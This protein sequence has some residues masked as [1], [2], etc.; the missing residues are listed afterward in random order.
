MLKSHTR[1]QIS[2]VA[3][4]QDREGSEMIDVLIRNFDG[5][6]KVGMD[7]WAVYFEASNDCLL[8]FYPKGMDD[9]LFKL[10]Y[11]KVMRIYQ[12]VT[13][14]TTKRFYTCSSQKD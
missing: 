6:M 14:E 2:Y 5:V 8:S 4:V 3:T 11:Y 12:A 13:T 7:V 1:S 10:G 9:E